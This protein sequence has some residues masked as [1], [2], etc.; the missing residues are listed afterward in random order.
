MVAPAT[1]RAR[2]AV[3]W[4]RDDCHFLERSGLLPERWELVEGEI[5]SKMGTNRPHAMFAKRMD[6]WLTRVFGADFVLPA[7]SIDVAPGDNPTS[8]PE[9]DILVVRRPAAELGLNP[10][11]ADIALLI[12]V[13][14]TTLDHDLGPKAG[15]YA[16]AGI[17]DYWVVDINAGLIHQ[18]RNPTM[19]GYA[20]V[21]VVPAGQRLSPLAQPAAELDPATL[22]G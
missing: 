16:R 9:P 20:S 1:I 14:D 8:K 7:C 17:A 3:M 15:L 6:V 13:S 19:T 18:H 11:A 21:Q 12:E 2:N 10:T 4:T 5:I 22:F